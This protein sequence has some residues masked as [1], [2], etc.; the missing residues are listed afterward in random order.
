MTEYDAFSAVR[1]SGVS[2]GG[3]IRRRGYRLR[4]HLMGLVIAALLPSMLVCGTLAFYTTQSYRAAVEARLRDTSYALSLFVDSKLSTVEAALRSLSTANALNEGT[5]LE[6]LAGFGLRAREAVAD[7]M[8]DIFVADP[9]PGYPVVLS[10][11]IPSGQ[12]AP[13]APSTP[14][15]A[16]ALA[17]VFT[18]GKPVVGDLV[19]SDT[20]GHYTFSVLVPVL[21]D[22]RV[23]RVIGA[24][25]D[26]LP[27]SE[28]L[29][30]QALARETIVGLLDS[31][32]VVVARSRDQEGTVGR[33]ATAPFISALSDRS[34][35][36]FSGRLFSGDRV[37]V[38]FREIP[39]E[40]GW[41]ILVTAPE[42]SLMGGWQDP[43]ALIALVGSL[44]ILIG[45]ALST[46]L[47]HRLLRPIAALSSASRSVAYGVGT[48][49]GIGKA[50]SSVLEFDSLSE[51]ILAAEGALLQAKD[52][53]TET[54]ESI[55]DNFYAFD[56]EWRFIYVNG[57]A[58][59]AFARTR[60]DL[61]GRR[62]HD[63][64]PEAE[65]NV[66]HANL[67]RA[68]ADGRSS[69]FEAVSSITGRWSSYTVYPRKGGGLSV[70]FRDIT[71]RM[72]TEGAMRASEER[73]RLAVDGTGMGTWDKD[74]ASGD[75]TWS[76][77]MFRLFGYAAEADG[78][79]TTEMWR[80]L[81]HPEDIGEVELGWAEALRETGDFRSTHRIR[82][83][84]DGATRWIETYGRVLRGN[85]TLGRFVGVVFDVTDRRQGEERR[86]TLARE[87]DHRAKNVLAV[88]Q[89]VLRLTPA[90]EPKRFVEIVEGR[91]NCL[92][93][94]H[95]QLA[96]A[97]WVG[98][99][100]RQLLRG[101]LSACGAEGRVSLDGPAVRLEPVAV[102][103]F[104]LAAHEMTT[105]AVRHGALS[106]PEGRVN[107]S[108]TSEPGTGRLRF[109]WREVGGPPVVTPPRRK[110]FGIK[111]IEMSTKGQ[112]S[113]SVTFDWD[114]AGLGCE[115]FVDR[116]LHEITGVNPVLDTA[117]PAR[118]T[119][120]AKLSG[121][122]ILVV[123]DEPLVAMA[124]RTLLTQAGCSVVGPAETL[125]E[126]VRLVRSEV[127]RI[128]AA[129]LDVNLRGNYSFPAADLLIAAGV[130]V[131]YATGY[132][133]MP[134]GRGGEGFAVL[135]KP[136]SAE[137]MI[138]ALSRAIA[139]ASEERK[140]SP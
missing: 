120:T 95:T 139:H 2:G 78:R 113:G 13:S 73:M 96:D 102:Q 131:V 135:R 101:E 27:F 38:A 66:V 62:L 93:R 43:V 60:D 105:N 29:G 41:K 112:M 115:L 88:V 47:G 12:Q 111:L 34:E 100:I 132:G 125:D 91:V 109:R 48:A 122:R 107:A 18:T 97:K 72:A 71:E 121:C 3:P 31:Q 22:G 8:L 30:N 98:V 76:R 83:S 64:F 80:G 16:R 67:R 127:D 140:V 136:V 108:W 54:L 130:P 63:T 28:I 90:E 33:R 117:P 61:F 59:K 21:R 56:H 84:D 123:E 26:P 51:D 69:S 65:G 126:A 50:R 82:R 40:R 129:L 42:S 138:D 128:D 36:G 11:A 25:V 104:T 70:F 58:L 134:E 57:H 35:G 114:P 94:A 110:G 15:M 24:T 119:F 92:A 45:A 17:R 39:D 124:I 10:T 9:A 49:P 46:W 14:E 32:Y 74:L 52:E 55:T 89:A 85:G 44:A 4:T 86:A 53:A 20:S 99:D 75:T 103:A 87:V 19:L 116:S 133:D 6:S 23:I 118:A 37:I 1:E 7:E 137:V 79:A 5:T 77:Q 68:A 106:V 81:I